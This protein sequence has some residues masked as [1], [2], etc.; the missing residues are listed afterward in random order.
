MYALFK[1]TYDYYE[2]DNF[3][4]ASDN[5]NKLK[6]YYQN[7]KDDEPL[8]DECEYDSYYSCDKAHYCIVEIKVV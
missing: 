2:W 1:R 4:V 5:I 8:I 7:L 6:D 3:I